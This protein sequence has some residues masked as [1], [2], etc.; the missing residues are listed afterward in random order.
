MKVKILWD[1]AQSMGFML[2][3]LNSHK[4]YQ[5]KY[6]DFG[7]NIGNL[8]G[9]SN[10]VAFLHLQ[11]Y[12]VP[13]LCLLDEE[14]LPGWCHV[15]LLFHWHT[16][17]SSFPPPALCSLFLVSVGTHWSIGTRRPC[18]HN[19]G[20]FSGMD[21]GCCPCPSVS[22]TVRGGRDTEIL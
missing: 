22:W 13:A 16:G 5:L 4:K 15:L 20:A 9:D 6:C 21:L 18:R 14:G 10:S 17:R 11:H 1:S 12:A 19:A 8:Q 2:H 3:L 7:R